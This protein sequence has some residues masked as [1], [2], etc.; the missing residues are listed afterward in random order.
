[1][2]SF[3]VKVQ[4]SSSWFDS[5]IKM[6]KILRVLLHNVQAFF[7][8]IFSKSKYLRDLLF[9]VCNILVS[10]SHIYFQFYVRL[11]Y[12]FYMQLFVVLIFSQKCY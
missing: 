5:Q 3:V 2:L 1:M 11:A 12:S 8:L 6:A 7:N 4:Y 10:T 9:R